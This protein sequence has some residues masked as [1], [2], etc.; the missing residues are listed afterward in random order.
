MTHEELLSRASS[1]PERLWWAF[2]F[3]QDVARSVKAATPA[4]LER[5]AELFVQLA[6][7]DPDWAA[8]RP[9]GRGVP[10]AA[11]R[12]PTQARR[13]RGREF[14]RPSSAGRRTH[15]RCGSIHAR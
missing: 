7:T 8:E 3:V 2:R 15:S 1:G 4:Q 12:T 9:L 5:A 14:G 13:S 11:C 6:M 10:R